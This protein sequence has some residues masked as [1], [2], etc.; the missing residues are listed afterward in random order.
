MGIITNYAV[1]A[2]MKASHP[3]IDR[4]QCWNLHPHRKQCTDCKDICPYGDTIFTRPNMVKDWNPCTDCGLCVSVCRSRCISP[5]SDQIEHDLS[6]ADVDNDTVW[7]GCEKSTRHNDAVRSCICA[8]SWETLAYIALN[9]RVVLDL[10]P[11]GECENDQCAAQL[12]AELTRLV[13]F[14]GQPLFETFFTLAYEPEQAPYH[15]RELSRREM[16]SHVTDTSRNGT[17]R[18]LRMLPGLQ[19]P[20]R[21]SSLDFRLMLN[22]RIKQ[23]REA[24]TTPVRYGWYLPAVNNKCFGCGK[25]EKACR[26]GALKLEDLPD[27]QTRIVVTP[28]KCSECG[29]CVSACSY[30]AIEGMKLRQLTSLG[31]VSIMKFRKSVCIDCGKPIAPDSVDG[32]CSVCRIKIRSKKRQEETAARAK[33]RAAERAA[34]RA[35]EAEAKA[36][37]AAAQSAE[38]ADAAQSVVAAQAEPAIADAAAAVQAVENT[39]AVTAADAAGAVASSSV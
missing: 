1:G 6:P 15:A 4:R 23:L 3:E 35:A 9:R 31:P 12:R 26:A 5:S 19:D 10:T 22:Q 34:K 8:F 2:L 29:M 24:T 25:C 28:W 18:L 33:A 39:E 17:K 14:F 21:G 7:I 37:E 20:D 30:H 27:G 38:A 32:R 11:C 16:F 13:E 36:A